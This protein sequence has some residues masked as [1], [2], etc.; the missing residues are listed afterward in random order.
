[1]KW[2]DKIIN[3]T[4]KEPEGKWS[5]KSL[6]MFVSFVMSII[7]GTIIVIS[8]FFTDTEIGKDSVMVFFGFLT[9]AGYKGKLTLDDKKNDRDCKRRTNNE[10]I[11]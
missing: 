7:L 4:L 8:H 10:V 11:G 6:T 9:L 3:D 5:R 2:F 1:M